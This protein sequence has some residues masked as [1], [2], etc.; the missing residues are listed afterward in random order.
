MDG[1]D[2]ALVGQIGT[3]LGKTIGIETVDAV[4]V[5][6][7]GHQLHAEAEVTS[8]ADLPLSAAHAI[9]EDARHQLLHQVRR[10]S[11]VIIR[12]V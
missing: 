7:I 9:A 3:V 1:V 4:R 12:C 5:R 2:P 10:L 8:D 6:W 11:S